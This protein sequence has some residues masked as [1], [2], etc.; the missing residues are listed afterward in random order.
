MSKIVVMGAGGFIGNHMVSYLV[1]NNH[2]VIAVD[3]KK[4]E[5]NNSDANEFLILDLSKYESMSFIDKEVSE[6]YQFAADM[7]GAGYIFTGE[8]DFN[9]MSNSA[10]INLNLLTYLI[11][12]NLSPKIFYSSSACVYPEEKQMTPR[13]IGLKEADAYPANPD[14]EYGWEKIFSERLYLSA[15]KN[16]GINVKIARYHNVYGPLSS[17]NNGKEKSPAALC[18]KVIENINGEVEIWGDGLQTRSYLYID[19]CIDGSISLM[20]SNYSGPY[21]IGSDEDISI[22]DLVDLI[23]KIENKKIKKIHI[24]GPLGVVGRNSD[25]S[26]SI[27]E[28]KW[29]PKTSLKDGIKKTYYWIK[30]QTGV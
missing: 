25:N 14:S 9:I 16:Y 26:K 17:W 20:K 5:F 13:H 4:P 2:Y 27:N 30:S 22:N 12:N 21:N 7:G 11:K 29:S 15:N 6:I 3:I 8:N 1:K 19:D 28:L 10:L 23:A 24:K 18:R